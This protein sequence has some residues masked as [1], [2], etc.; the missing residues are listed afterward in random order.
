MQKL[1][2]DTRLAAATAAGAD[3]K[4]SSCF[5]LSM[6]TSVLVIAVLSPFSLVTLVFQTNFLDNMP[7]RYLSTDVESPSVISHKNSGGGNIS[8][9]VTTSTSTSTRTMNG[10]SAASPACR[11]SWGKNPSQIGRIYFAHT[12]KAG[13]SYLR[14]FLSHASKLHNWTFQAKEGQPVEA[15]RQDTLYV[16]ALRHPI[17]RAI[18]HYKYE[19]RWTCPEMVKNKTVFVPTPE[20]SRTLKD[21]IKRIHPSNTAPCFNN[22]STNNSTIR[23]PILWVC[24][25]LCYLRWF[26]ADFNC[27]TNVSKSYSTALERLYNQFHLIAVTDWLKI[28]EYRRGLMEMFGINSSIS[29][30]RGMSCDA[31][32]KYW[33]QKYPAVLRNET[34]NQ[35]RQVNKLDIQLYETLTNCPGGVVFPPRLFFHTK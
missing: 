28:P 35:L 32:S 30:R 25:K 20:N 2:Q 1:Q 16:T 9:N 13:G 24:T 29:F 22:S 18:S 7:Y 27:L 5:S 10:W 8:V 14:R 19:G 23:K 12:R 34:L 3:A 21:F 17:Q 33:N 26:G 11:P 4:P 6:R 15:R 31:Q